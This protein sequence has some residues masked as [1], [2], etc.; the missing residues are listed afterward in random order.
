ARPPAWRRLDRALLVGAER[1]E[2]HWI[3]AGVWPRDEERSVHSLWMAE[4]R[5]SRLQQRRIARQREDDLAVLDRREDA[6]AGEQMEAD[7]A[8]GRVPAGGKRLQIGA[9]RRIE[10]GAIAGEPRPVARALGLQILAH[11]GQL[12]ARVRADRVH[13][14]E[15][16]RSE[17]HTSELQSR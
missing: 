8:R 7:I 10:D 12:A 4:H 11:P 14:G 9:R 13:G 3:R 15:P 6:V 5:S 1:R 2:G 16:G 17:E